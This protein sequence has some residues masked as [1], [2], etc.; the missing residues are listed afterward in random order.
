M[1]TNRI[2]ICQK[3]VM[4]IAAALL[5]A[6]AKPTLPPQQMDKSPFTGTPCAAPCWRGLAVGKSSEDSVMSTLPTLTFI[7]QNTIQVFR[8][9]RPTIDNSAFAPGMEVTASCVQSNQQC[10]SLTVLE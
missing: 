7:D 6:C 1:I 9:S 2:R 3:V 5:F 4:S 8:G 10:L